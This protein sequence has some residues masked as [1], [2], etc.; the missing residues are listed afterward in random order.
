MGAASI[1]P[2]PLWAR[3]CMHVVWPLV[4]LVLTACALPVLVVGSAMAFVDRK[5]RLLRVTAMVV[6]FLWVDLRLLFGCWRLW[7]ASPRKDSPTWRSDHERLLVATLDEMMALAKRWV[8]FEVVL[9]TP[10]WFGREGA[11]LLAFARHAGPGDSFAIAWL[12]ARTA[13]RLP[14]VV[15]AEALR[16][17]P[18]I[19]TVLTVLHSYFVP[20]TSRPGNDRAQGVLDLAE[21]LEPN[22]VLVLFPEG[23][24][25][26]LARRQRIVERLK[27]AG[28][29]NRLRRAQRLRSVLPVKT[30]GFVETVQAR[31]DADVMIIAHAG[32][33]RLV[34]PKDIYDAVPFQVPF[35]VRTW[36]YAASELP[37]GEAAIAAWLEEHWDEVDAWISEHEYE[38]ERQAEESRRRS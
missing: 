38:D 33:G 27:A 24:N 8:G 7:F 22:D 14:R 17:D 29:V 11:P 19:D 32:L 37:T 2:P 16:W 31:P 26:S 10:M 35:L 6:L 9:D 4:V 36:T 13:G 5:A 25:W 20:A 21:S 34:K 23:Q 18:G 28:S 15:L 12:L 3:R 30:K 1:P